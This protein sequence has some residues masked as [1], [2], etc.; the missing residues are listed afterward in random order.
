MKTARFST[1]PSFFFSILV[2]TTNNRDRVYYISF[3]VDGVGRRARKRRGARERTEKT[4]QA[5][6]YSLPPLYLPVGEDCRDFR[7]ANEGKNWQDDFQIHE[8]KTSNRFP[9]IASKHKGKGNVEMQ[10]TETTH[11]A[12]EPPQLEYRQPRRGAVPP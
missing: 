10:I 12:K 11:P 8:H 2:A 6:S 7:N 4:L 3:I 5:P 1:T 9:P